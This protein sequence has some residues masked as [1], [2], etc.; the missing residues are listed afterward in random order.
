MVS[1]SLLKFAWKKS[2]HGL[3]GHLPDSLLAVHL[4]GNLQ[5]LKDD[6]GKSFNIYAD[7]MGH[8]P[9]IQLISK[10]NFAFIL[11]HAIWGIMLTIKTERHAALKDM[12]LQTKVQ[13]GLRA[14]WAYW[15]RLSSSSWLFT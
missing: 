5:L 8:N 10:G 1:R 15:V 6:A 4:A 3:N 13:S 14:T 7:F 12:P 11:L 9:L 2:A